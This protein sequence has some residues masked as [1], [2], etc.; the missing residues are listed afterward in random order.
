MP[1][2][3]IHEKVR[4]LVNELLGDGANEMDL[5]YV[6]GFFA[7]SMEQWAKYKNKL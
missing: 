5:S 4:L 2:D 6:L 7:E 3:Q 1:K